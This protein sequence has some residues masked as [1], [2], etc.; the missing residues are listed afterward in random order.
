M[1]DR[2]K[3]DA[4]DASGEV[5]TEEK[6]AP[7]D[8]DEELPQTEDAPAPVPVPDAHGA[9]LASWGFPRFA[10]DFPR[11]PEL[12]A[13]VDAFARGDY[14]TVRERA[15]TLAASPDA[16]PDVKRA[17]QLLRARIDPDKTGRTFFA[18]AAALL[19][20]L[21]VWWVT[22]D[23]PEHHAPAPPVVPPAVEFV[24]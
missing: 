3:V 18:L 22:H 21:T 5:E 12:D 10:L 8:P 1:T 16:P 19:V 6:P 17:A 4:D 23:G 7:K 2:A 24:K 14:A 15:P 11:E 20:F 13:L 9:V